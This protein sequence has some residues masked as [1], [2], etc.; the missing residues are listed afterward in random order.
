LA[1]VSIFKDIPD[2][3]VVSLIQKRKY[4]VPAFFQVGHL[5]GIILVNLL[6]LDFLLN[7][8]IAVLRNDETPRVH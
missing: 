6:I 7:I 5:V 4:V 3:L 8:V 2:S 1:R